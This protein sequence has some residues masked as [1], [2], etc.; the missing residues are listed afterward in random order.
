MVDNDSHQHCRA[1][2][3]LGGFILLPKMILELLE[4]GFQPILWIQQNAFAFCARPDGH[5]GTTSMAQ[6]PVLAVHI[7]CRWLTNHVPHKLCRSE[8]FDEPFNQPRVALA[9]PPDS[10]TIVIASSHS[11]SQADSPLL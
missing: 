9:T 2:H 6:Q 8:V 1:K 11:D 4:E 10:S 5:L 7:L 3:G